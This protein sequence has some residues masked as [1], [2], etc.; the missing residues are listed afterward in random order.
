MV[1][2]CLA[3]HAIK[4]T[5]PR[6]C[7]GPLSRNH[8]VPVLLSDEEWSRVQEA[9]QRVGLLPATYLR[10]AA[11]TA[12]AAA[13][14]PRPGRYELGWIYREAKSRDHVWTEAELREKNLPL[15]WC[16][17]WVR[18]QLAE[19]RNFQEMAVEAGVSVRSVNQH[20]REY[21]GISAYSKLEEKL[22]A[23]IRER[24]ANGV[25]RGA[26]AAEFGVTIN[27]V[28]TY[29]RGLKTT[30]DRLFEARVEQVGDWPTSTDV[31]ARRCFEGNRQKAQAWCKGMVNAGRL[32]RLT[33]GWFALANK[34]SDG[35][36]VS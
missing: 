26:V 7:E 34:E 6:R 1:F 13:H 9:A 4:F 15:Y 33:R 25:S 24:V 21:H 28:S 30:H 17:A 14:R 2:T 11:L 3:S 19:G 22:R 27:T 29:T 32:Q 36:E 35:A 5:P 16:E 20:V 18:A 23:A 10:A 12:A 8:T 31:I